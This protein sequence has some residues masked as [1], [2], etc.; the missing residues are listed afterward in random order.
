MSIFYFIF[1]ICNY[2]QPM[3]NIISYHN[4]TYHNSLSVQSRYAMYIAQTDCCDIYCY[5]CAFVGYN[6]K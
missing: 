1:V 4:S 5:N 2:N 6:L 3:H